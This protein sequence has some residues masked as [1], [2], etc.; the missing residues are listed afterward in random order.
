MLAYRTARPHHPA[1]CAA[2]APGR[3]G[4]HLC[5]GCDQVAT[6]QTRRHATDTEYAALPETLRPID[7]VAHQAVYGCDDCAEDWA[8]L[9]CEHP[10]PQP[11]P[12]PVCGATGD[13]ACTRKDRTTP[14]DAPHTARIE[15]QPAPGT[16]AHAHA[17][18]CPVFAGC[19]CDPADPAPTRPPR[20][21]DPAGWEP[22]TS[23][24]TEALTPQIA[25]WLRE[26]DIDPARVTAITNAL[27]QDNRPG[28]R[29]TT[30]RVGPD[31]NTQFDAHGHP[32]TDTVLLPIEG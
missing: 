7:G 2:C 28:R 14:R 15:A 23:G 12:C 13:Q 6:Q 25:G 21:A 4:H 8:P 20:F 1:E 11:A 16:C 3:P 5:Q 29:I 10:E 26:H 27:T 9:P 17:P 30:T 32:L 31:G 24:L 22:D 18:G 19:R